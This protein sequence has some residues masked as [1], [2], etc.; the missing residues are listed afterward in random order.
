MFYEKNFNLN[1]D[2]QISSQALLDFYRELEKRK[3]A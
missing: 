2:F 3:K 1:Y